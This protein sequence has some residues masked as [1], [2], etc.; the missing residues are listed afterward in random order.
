MNCVDHTRASNMLIV[1][2]LALP[3]PVELRRVAGQYDKGNVELSAAALPAEAAYAQYPVVKSPVDQLTVMNFNTYLMDVMKHFAK[4]PDLQIRS[5][6]ISEWFRSLRPQEV[7][8]VLVLNE[9]FSTPAANLIRALC[10]P[11]WKRKSR[12][13]KNCTSESHFQV[14]TGLIHP[15]KGSFGVATK[16]RIAEAVGLK[17]GGVVILLRK[18]VELLHSECHFFD[19]AMGADYMAY[20]GYHAV[21]LRKRS[22]ESD[23]EYRDYLVFG[24]HLQAYEGKEKADVRTEQLQMMKA[25]VDKLVA[26]APATGQGQKL[27][28]VYAGDLNVFASEVEN[29]GKTLLAS[30]GTLMPK[31]F[32]LKSNR[33]Q[34]TS[35][36]VFRNDYLFYDAEEVALGSQPFDQ[37]LYG[38]DRSGVEAPRDARYQ[39]LPVKADACFESELGLK[40]D[41]LSDHYAVFGQFCWDSDADPDDHFAGLCNNIEQVQGHV[42]S[43]KLGSQCCTGAQEQRI[44][45]AQ[46]QRCVDT[47]KGNTFATLIPKCKNI[48]ASSINEGS[49]CWSSCYTSCPKSTN[50]SRTSWCADSNSIPPGD[51]PWP[52][53]PPPCTKKPWKS[54]CVRQLCYDVEWHAASKGQ[55][56]ATTLL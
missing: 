54:G 1:L 36:D 38:T 32:W 18:G 43:T 35:A 15:K 30:S 21:Q 13:P 41:D 45:G 49:P 4:K 31:G 51:L 34:V 11:D 19:H 9:I 17:S 50:S 26:Q 10:T 12:K 40:T 23:D 24:S 33:S 29:A 28:V 27:R 7:P 42:G 14:A 3:A 2:L 16:S 25:H 44:F 20:K 8:D 22:S 52:G 47:R 37:L 48:D 55:A 53:K 39:Y 6:R 56:L 46:E 5:Q